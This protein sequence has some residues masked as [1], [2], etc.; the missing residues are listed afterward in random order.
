[1]AEFYREAIL[2]ATEVAGPMLSD[3][4]IGD[5]STW[6]G[7]A[8]ALERLTPAQRCHAI[9]AD[10]LM[11]LHVSG[12]SSHIQ[13]RDLLLGQGALAANYLAKMAQNADDA[14]ASSLLMAME[15]GWLLVANN[16]RSLSPLN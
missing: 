8:R 6:E 11:Q 12:G 10:W 1:M 5:L 3:A 13:I 15:D 4:E 7:V 16:G 14:G 2:A 9:Y